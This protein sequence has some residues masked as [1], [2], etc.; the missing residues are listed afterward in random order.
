MMV[1]RSPAELP[2][3]L[4]RC[5]PVVEVLYLLLLASRMSEG[6]TQIV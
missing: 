1:L 3:G 6:L 4:T 5:R 2:H